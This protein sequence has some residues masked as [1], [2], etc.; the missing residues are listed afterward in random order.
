MHL[1]HWLS[2]NYIINRIT[3]NKN[4]P[5]KNVSISGTLN[6]DK[7]EQG[8]ERE[9]ES[10]KAL[11]CQQNI[12]IHTKFW[13]QTLGWLLYKF[14]T[15]NKNEWMNE[16]RAVVAAFEHNKKRY[17]PTCQHSQ[18]LMSCTAQHTSTKPMPAQFVWFIHK[19]FARKRINVNTLQAFTGKI[20]RLIHTHTQH[21]MKRNAW[22]WRK[23]STKTSTAL[24]Y[25]SNEWWKNT[26]MKCKH[27]SSVKKLEEKIGIH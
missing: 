2:V 5:S 10:G 19:N 8:A 9:S 26:R 23:N 12:N 6:T 21:W 20:H 14:H 25:R 17:M 22:I 13:L 24:R 18:N 16:K 27:K 4:Q 11:E 1:A 3:T 15:L 7:K